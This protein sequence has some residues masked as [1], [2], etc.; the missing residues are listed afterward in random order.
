MSLGNALR[1]QMN[2]CVFLCVPQ[3]TKA[4]TNY[5]TLIVTLL[6]GSLI[7]LKKIK[8][9]QKRPLRRFLAT[10]TRHKI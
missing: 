9:L 10:T 8:V 2:N 5:D 4:L 6:E 3:Q 7:F 1:L